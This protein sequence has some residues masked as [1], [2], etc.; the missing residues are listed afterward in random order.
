MTCKDCIHCELCDMYSKFGITD[1]NEY[2]TT[3]CGLFKD[4]SK[5]IELPCKVG[6]NLRHK[7]IHIAIEE[8]KYIKELI[9]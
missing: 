4:K 5:L 9:K 6:H 1:V 3:I 8:Q 2:D 7:L